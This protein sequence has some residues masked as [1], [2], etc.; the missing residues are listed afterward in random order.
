MDGRTGSPRRIKIP[1][2]GLSY[3]HTQ[4]PSEDRHREENAWPILSAE[5]CRATG[6]LARNAAISSLRRYGLSM[7]TTAAS[8]MSGRARRA[9]TYS[10]PRCISP[11]SATQ[12]LTG[13]RPRSPHACG[14]PPRNP[15]NACRPA[16]L[17]HPWQASRPAIDPG[18]HRAQNPGPLKKGGTSA[19]APTIGRPR[20]I[21]VSTVPPSTA[22]RVGQTGGTIP[23]VHASPFCRWLQI[24]VP[25]ARIGRGPVA[26]A[27]SPGNRSRRSNPTFSAIEANCSSPV[28]A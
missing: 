13:E 7:S 23:H 12:R 24:S 16:D 19:S 5:P 14:N 22:T 2:A 11:R 3:F 1:P 17:A 6:H 26:R 20:S 25:S 21:A 9:A 8:G 10:R 4:V 18:H 15:L 28:G 27:D